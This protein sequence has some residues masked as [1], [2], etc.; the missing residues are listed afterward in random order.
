MASNNSQVRIIEPAVVAVLLPCGISRMAAIPVKT[1][2][3]ANNRRP[4][5]MLISSNRVLPDACIAL[6]PLN[7]I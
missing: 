7:A 4:I 3:A 6:R 5:F 1:P 2:I